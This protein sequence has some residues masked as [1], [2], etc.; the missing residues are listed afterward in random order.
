MDNESKELEIVEG[1][2]TGINMSPVSNHIISIEQK[3]K[4]AKKL[5]IPK[6]STTNKKKKNTK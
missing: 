3:N 6:E 2:G 1:D 5:I 4:K